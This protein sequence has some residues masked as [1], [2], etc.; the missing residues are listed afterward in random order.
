MRLHKR[1][2][3]TTEGSGKGEAAGGVVGEAK[4]VGRAAEEEK[5]KE[6]GCAEE[7]LEEATEEGREV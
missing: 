6:E 7:D 4:V 3:W 1:S 5:E 2:G